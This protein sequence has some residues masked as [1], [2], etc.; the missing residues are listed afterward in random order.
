MDN[1]MLLCPGH[2]RLF[3]EGHYTID[4]LGDGRFTFHR[5]DGRVIAPPPLRA[6]PDAAPTTSGCP[7]AQGHGERYD[8]DLTLDALIS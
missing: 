6:Q 5:P 1:L 4:A 3:H 7:T 2:H 8:L